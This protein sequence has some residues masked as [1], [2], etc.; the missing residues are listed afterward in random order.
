MWDDDIDAIRGHPPKMALPLA[1][2][3][4]E[5]SDLVCQC[6]VTDENGLAMKAFA[7]NPSDDLRLLPF[8]SAKTDNAALKLTYVRIC[9]NRRY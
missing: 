1:R 2:A 9:V 7:P 3:E 8:S 5:I 4:L 6:D